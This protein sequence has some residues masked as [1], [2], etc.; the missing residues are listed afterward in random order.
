MYKYLITLLFLT[1]LSCKKSTEEQKSTF[2]TSHLVEHQIDFLS[3]SLWLSPSYEL[4][5]YNEMVEMLKTEPSQAFEF[6][7]QTASSYENKVEKPVYFQDDLATENIIVIYPMPY[8]PIDKQTASLWISGMVSNMKNTDSNN[9]RT[10]EIMEK[11]IKKFGSHQMVK[12]KAKQ[13]DVTGNRR[14]FAQYYIS[15][16]L[17]SFMVI[18]IDIFNKDIEDNLKVLSTSSK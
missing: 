18:H 11:R 1:F 9:G 4:I 6:L 5:T 14:Y 2:D 7:I 15:G 16:N 10:S 13:T 3:T 12:F 8:Q 17:N